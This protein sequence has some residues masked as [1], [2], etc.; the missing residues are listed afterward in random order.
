MGENLRLIR[1]Y[2]ALLALFT[3]GRWGLGLGGADYEA[4]HQVFSI[5]IL[6]LL[7]SAYHA[8]VIRGFAGGGIKRALVVG[9]LLGAISQAVILVSTAISY[10]AGMETFFNYPRALNVEEAIPFGQ[11]MG[12]RAITFVA[13][14][15]TNT[16][17]AA[18][19]YGIATLTGPKAGE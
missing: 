14:I 11:A 4:T 5:V 16:V 7:S 19:G 9:A 6:T 13:G 3:V 10:M 2:L 1:F 15:V 18:L 12:G 17:A 8:W